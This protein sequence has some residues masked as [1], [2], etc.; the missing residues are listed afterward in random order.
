MLH[1]QH[2]TCA[3]SGLKSPARRAGPPASIDCTV[4]REGRWLGSGGGCLPYEDYLCGGR[5]WGRDAL[6]LRFNFRP[7]GVPGEVVA[8]CLSILRSRCFCC[9]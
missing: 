5:V 1:P 6:S 9:R 4:F 2:Q 8:S 3:P 7:G